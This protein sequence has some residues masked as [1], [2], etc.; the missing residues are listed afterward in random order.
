MSLDR[1]CVVFLESM[2][3]PQIGKYKILEEIGQG[4]MG[5]VYRGIDEQTGKVVAIKQFRAEVAVPALIYFKTITS[6]SFFP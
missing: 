6:T 2:I 3:A 1:I 5:T 4:G